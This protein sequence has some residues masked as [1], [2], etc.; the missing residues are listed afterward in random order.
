LDSFLA[1]AA[2]I[3]EAARSCTRAGGQAAPWTILLGAGGQIE[4]LA[5]SG[6]AL[7]ALRAERGAAMVFRVA[8]DRG[9]IAVDGRDGSRSCRL[10]A[11]SP[12]AVARRLLSSRPA[13]TIVP[14]APPAISP[15]ASR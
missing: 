9:R 14:P 8:E 3:L 4:M 5:D 11:E 10:E 2:S 1:N 6:W 13:Y 7:D 12:A 15:P